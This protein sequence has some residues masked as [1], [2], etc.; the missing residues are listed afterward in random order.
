RTFKGS[1]SPVRG[2]AFSPD[3]KTLWTCPEDGRVSAWD[4]ATG[5]VRASL[6]A[7]GNK[8]L[9]MAL[10]PDGKSVLT[11]GTMEATEGRGDDA[12]KVDAGV[13]ALYSAG[14]KSVW[15]EVNPS[16]VRAVAFS[17]DGKRVAGA[18]DDGSVLI[19]DAETGKGLMAPGH[20]RGHGALAAVAF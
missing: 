1:D 3:G 10:S 8:W 18:C 19:R 15:H 6:N 11:A 17:P 20:G 13:M 12:R 2:V 5:K 16:A 4:V 7:D 9:A 14:L